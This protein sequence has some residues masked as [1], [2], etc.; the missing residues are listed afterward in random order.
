MSRL[1]EHVWSNLIF[2]GGAFFY[3]IVYG[4]APFLFI[5]LVLLPTKWFTSLRKVYF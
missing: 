1:G 4:L 5:A 2:L 3:G